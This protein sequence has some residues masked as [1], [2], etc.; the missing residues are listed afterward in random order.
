[1]KKLK[2]I[3][4][5]REKKNRKERQE[6][7]KME[8]RLQV[9][10]FIAPSPSMQLCPGKQ[11]RTSL[12]STAD[13]WIIF[14]DT[15]VEHSINL[16]YMFCLMWIQSSDYCKL[17]GWQVIFLI[18]MGCSIKA[19]TKTLWILILFLNALQKER[20]VKT[21]IHICWVMHMIQN[22]SQLFERV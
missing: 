20:F 2:E 16:F 8:G 10:H 18:I 1:M 19:K 22:I 3:E 4:G 13:Y 6:E 17:V 9:M 15:G 14:L 11:S 21:E 5:G 7:W 12:L